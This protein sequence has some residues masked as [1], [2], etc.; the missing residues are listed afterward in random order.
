MLLV[1]YEEEEKD[2]WK[3]DVP[4]FVA[5]IIADLPSCLLMMPLSDIFSCLFGKGEVLK[6]FYLH[7]VAAAQAQTKLPRATAKC[8]QNFWFKNFK[9][10]FF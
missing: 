2:I 5:C 8:P 7:L 3:W 1:K 6:L 4:S 10:K 9:K